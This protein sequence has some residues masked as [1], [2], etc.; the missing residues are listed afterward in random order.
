[1]A[2]H[3]SD[4]YT[5]VYLVLEGVSKQM[6]SYPPVLDPF[7]PSDMVEKPKSLEIDIEK[8]DWYELV[9]DVQI[10]TQQPKKS[11]SVEKTKSF[12]IDTKKVSFQTTGQQAIKKTP[13]KSDIY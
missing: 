1:M 4:Y 8:V 3:E 2:L 10:T 7:L 6:K 11:T 5:N 12:K 13:G 9:G